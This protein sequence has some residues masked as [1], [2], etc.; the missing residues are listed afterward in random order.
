[1]GSKGYYYYYYP[2]KDHKA[3][4]KFPK[5]KM[6]SL[7]SFPSLHLPQ[8]Y[9]K[10]G[11]LTSVK[12]MGMAAATGLLVAGGLFLSLPIIGLG[13]GRRSLNTIWE[14]E[15]FNRDNITPWPISSSTSSKLTNRNSNKHSRLPVLLFMFFFIG[16]RLEDDSHYL[17]GLFLLQFINSFFVFFFSRISFNQTFF[18]PPPPPPP[19]LRVTY[20]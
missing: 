11:G 5:F 14:S 10:D 16:I 6:P 17:L 20:F 13:V 15:Y 1:M 9:G 8:A 3:K 18:S 4:L 12:T 7:P 2:V 19:S